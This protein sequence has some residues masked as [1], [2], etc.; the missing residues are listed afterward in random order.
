MDAEARYATS[1]WTE[2]TRGQILSTLAEKQYE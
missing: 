1:F 2:A